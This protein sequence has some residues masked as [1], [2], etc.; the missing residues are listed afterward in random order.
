MNH[1]IVAVYDE[2]AECYG[3]P[4]V[5]STRGLA[6]RSFRDEVN[7]ASEDN[8]V[9]RHPEHFRLYCLAEFDDSSGAVSG[10]PVPELLGLASSFKEA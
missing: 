3:R 8:Q 7:R 1:V 4:V 10:L 2:A 5:V 9:Y 6:V